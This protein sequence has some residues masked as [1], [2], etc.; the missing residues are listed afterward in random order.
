MK[1]RA[2]LWLGLT[3]AV[4]CALALASVLPVSQSGHTA[5]VLSPASAALDTADENQVQKAVPV[6]SL[7]SGLRVGMALVTGPTS[8]VDKVKVVAQIEGDFKG[9]RIRALVPIET[10]SLKELHRVPETSVCGIADLKL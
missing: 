4:V 10:E 8:Q 1:A 3:C 5:G 6:L 2:A 7:G 9:A